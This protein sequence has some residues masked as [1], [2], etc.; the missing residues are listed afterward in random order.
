M[1]RAYVKTL[2]RSRKNTVRAPRKNKPRHSKQV[3]RAA[4]APVV[5]NSAIASAATLRIQ[6]QLRTHRT[7]HRAVPL[8]PRIIIVY[9]HNGAAQKQAAAEQTAHAR[10][11]SLGRA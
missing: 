5:L 6:R 8:Y 2:S 11:K 4:I 9:K 3:T 1:G 7:P 10:G